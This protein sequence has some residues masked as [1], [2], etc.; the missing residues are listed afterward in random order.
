MKIKGIHVISLNWTLGLLAITLAV[1]LFGNF[2]QLKIDRE[3]SILAVI[4]HKSGIASALAHNHIVYASNYK[5]KFQVKE[6]TTHPP[7]LNLELIIPATELVIDDPKTKQRWSSRLQ[8]L[9]IINTLFAN[10]NSEDRQ[11]IRQTMLSPDQLHAEHYPRITARIIS[12]QRSAADS[13]LPEF[14]L[15]LTT[16]VEIHGK[17][18]TLTFPANLHGDAKSGY[19]LE[20]FGPM[21]FSDFGIEPY[22]AFFGAV[23]NKDKFYV[24]AKIRTLSQQSASLPMPGPAT[25]TSQ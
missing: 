20:S 17:Q 10:I 19:T 1:P 15:Q 6:P 14:P 5:S 18:Q 23:G 9:G 13:S 7:D 2:K 21:R 24:Y 3:N 22:S 8:E 25:E 12:I 11:T 16:E 4:T